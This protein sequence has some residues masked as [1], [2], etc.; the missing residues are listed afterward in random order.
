MKYLFYSFACFF[1]VLTTAC[2]PGRRVRLP[3]SLRE[4]SG[5]ARHPD[6]TLWM[7]NDGGHPAVLHRVNPKNGHIVETRLLPVPNR[8]WEDLTCDKQG[9]LYIGDIGNNRNDRKDLRIYI[10]N[11]QNN[12]ADSI[13]FHYADQSHFPPALQK[14]RQFDCE[15]LVFFRDS[16]HL[17]TKSRFKSEHY[18]KHYVLPATAGRYTALLRDSVRL[19]GR[20]VSGAA[21]SADAHTLALT[22]YLVKMRFRFVPAAFATLWLFQD[23]GDGRFLRSTPRKKRLPKFLI[24]RQFESVVE[25]APGVWLAANESI[26]PQ[27]AALWRL[28]IRR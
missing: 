4:V 2:S 6:G 25:T 14:D 3:E 22:S 5:M 27:K 18:T 24:A 21:L 11:P 26:G 12:H 16:L 19:P 9:R 13:L 28:R 8:D 10:W 17:F 20:V 1:L 15:A 7:L 23:T